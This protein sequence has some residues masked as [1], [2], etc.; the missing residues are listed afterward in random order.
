MVYQSAGDR[1]DL[2][3]VVLKKAILDNLDSLKKLEKGQLLPP[4]DAMIS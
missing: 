2:Y 3:R 1:E 4:K